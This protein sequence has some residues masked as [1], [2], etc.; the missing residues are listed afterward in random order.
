MLLVQ[1]HS[2]AADVGKGAK[3][4]IGAYHGKTTQAK[5]SKPIIPRN[6]NVYNPIFSFPKDAKRKHNGTSKK[7]RSK[8]RI[9]R[10]FAQ[11]TRQTPSSPNP[12]L[13]KNTRRRT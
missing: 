8:T 2:P 7:T 11:A 9:T 5:T 1:V 6:G 12:L 10:L 4:P 13:A 3:K